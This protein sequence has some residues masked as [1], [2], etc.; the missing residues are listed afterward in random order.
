MDDLRD[1]IEQIIEKQVGDDSWKWLKDKVSNLNDTSQFNLAFSAIPR[2]IGK[3]RVHITEE[4][5]KELQQLRPGLSIEN[6]TIDRLCRVWLLMHL[7]A[8]NKEEYTRTI[9]NLFLTADMNEQV[10]LYS[11]LPVLA[12]PEYWQKR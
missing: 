8:S 9:E 3:E 2:K 1:Y 11:S 12:Y 6:W 5:V 4:Q 7:N 10:A